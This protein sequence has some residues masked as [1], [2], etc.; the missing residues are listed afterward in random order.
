MRGC[1]CCPLFTQ[2]GHGCSF[3]LLL[4]AAPRGFLE[5]S[6]S[7]APHA[8]HLGPSMAKGGISW[9]FHIVTHAE[10]GKQTAL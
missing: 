10:K 2:P 3:W 5:V 6:V 9:C 8:L 7:W 1:G 4:L